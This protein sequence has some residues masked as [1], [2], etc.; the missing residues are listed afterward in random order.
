MSSQRI[1]G[2]MLGIVVLIGC[3]SQQ[4]TV[5][6]VP[7]RTI[8]IRDPQFSGTGYE[9]IEVITGFDQIGH[10]IVVTTDG[11]ETC[12][13]GLPEGEWDNVTHRFTGREFPN[14]NYPIYLTIYGDGSGGTIKQRERDGSTESCGVFVGASK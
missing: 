6:N 13:V 7:D 8:Q 10:R 12:G 2:V 14:A 9:G 5:S 1:T 4:P 11:E 3:N